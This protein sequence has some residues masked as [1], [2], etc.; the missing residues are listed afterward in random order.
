[1]ISDHVQR[2]ALEMRQRIIKGEINPSPAVY[3]EMSPC[4]YCDF[5]DCCRF[6]KGTPGFSERRFK[7]IGKKDDIFQKMKDTIGE[8]DG[9]Q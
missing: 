6:D 4:R 7:K 2:K 1:M 5:N 9:V 8:S 3:D